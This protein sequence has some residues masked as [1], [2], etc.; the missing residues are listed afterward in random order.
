MLCEIG[1]ILLLFIAGLDTHIEELAQS[2]ASA[3]LSACL[4]AVLPFVAGLLA[5]PLFGFAGE[6]TLFVATALLAT[7]VGITVRVL[8]DLGFQRRRS[9]R[10]ILAA[11]VLDDMLGLMAL[12]VVTA[13]PLERPTPWSSPCWCSRPSSS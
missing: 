12:R 9:V 11:A 7:S 5:G 4:G 10:I 2:K 8:R 13:L 1:V 6:E 3:G